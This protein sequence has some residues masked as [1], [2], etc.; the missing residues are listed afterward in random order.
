[1]QYSRTFEKS[2]SHMVKVYT[3]I[4]FSIFGVNFLLE[5]FNTLIQVEILSKQTKKKVINFRCLNNGWPERGSRE[6]WPYYF[7][8]LFPS[9]HDIFED[10]GYLK[11]I[12]STRF[13]ETHRQ[14]TD[15]IKK[16]HSSKWALYFHEDNETENRNKVINQEGILTKPVFDNKLDIIKLIFKIP[17]KYQNKYNFATIQRVLD[18]ENEVI[19][20]PINENEPL[21]NPKFY[22]AQEEIQGGYLRKKIFMKMPNVKNINDLSYRNVPFCPIKDKYSIY[23]NPIPNKKV[24]MSEKEKIYWSENGQKKD[25]LRI[26]TSNRIFDEKEKNEIIVRWILYNIDQGFSK[27][28]IY[29]NVIDQFEN[30]SMPHFK[31]I[32]DQDLAEFIYYVFPYAYFFHEQISQETSCT[33]RNKGRTIWLGH[34]DVDERFFNTQTNETI[35]E[36]LK[37]FTQNNN[38]KEIGGL[39]TPN[40]WM[41]RLDDDT[42]FTDNN[43]REYYAK[44]KNI[45]VPD[46]VEFYYVH[47]VSSGKSSIRQDDIVNA[48]FKDINTGIVKFLNK[49]VSQRMTEINKK[50]TKK[51]KELLV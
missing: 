31:K 37:R 41:E 35:Y 36:Y 19:Y 29:V 2:N 17:E 32:I 26:C 47:L 34:D 6:F 14:Y 30:L 21:Y 15:R 8:P 10:N 51:I 27:P 44:A 42:T 46:N 3:I 13:I 12:L 40:E 43:N 33:E 1:M 24:E 5:Y 18:N 50:L 9:L 28:I 7:Y 45:I 25:L 16:L 22:I 39:L 38:V 48:H 23:V 49:S 11:V 4:L 20:R